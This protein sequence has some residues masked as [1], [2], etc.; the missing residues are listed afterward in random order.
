MNLAEAQEVVAALGAPVNVPRKKP[1]A[2]TPKSVELLEAEGYLCER[3]EHWNAFAHKKN[4]LW[5]FC[6]VL[7]VRRGEVLAV[8]VTDASNHAHRRVKIA[9]NEKVGRVR[10]AGIRIEIHGWRKVGNRWQVRR[11]DL[12]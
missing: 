8:Q 10:E 9:D 12:S 7:A 11:E 4:D 2:L 1:A 5:Q 6:D 3:V